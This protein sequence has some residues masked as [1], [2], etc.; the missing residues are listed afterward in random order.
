MDI[1]GNYRNVLTALTSAWQAHRRL[2]NQLL[3]AM[4]KDTCPTLRRILEKAYLTSVIFERDIEELYDSLKSYLHDS[5]LDETGFDPGLV[6]QHGVNVVVVMETITQQ[7]SA[8]LNLYKQ[9]LDLICKE[10]FTQE[11]CEQHLQTLAGIHAATSSKVQ[12]LFNKSDSVSL[13]TTVTPI[14]AQAASLPGRDVV[15]TRFFKGTEE[16]QGRFK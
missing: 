1:S 3:T 4:R 2:R 12:Q 9:L 11:W 10:G 13:A 16:I 6:R 14:P 5:R 7:Q 15:T 8:L